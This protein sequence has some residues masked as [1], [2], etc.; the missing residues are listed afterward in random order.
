V[1]PLLIESSMNQREPSKYV[2]PTLLE[3]KP[4]NDRGAAALQRVPSATIKTRSKTSDSDTA[5]AAD[6]GD[7]STTQV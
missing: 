4:I 7:S 1:S 6:G 2:L 3:D 5:R